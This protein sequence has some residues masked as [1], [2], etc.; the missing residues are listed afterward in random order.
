MSNGK[1]SKNIVD[2]SDKGMALYS[3]NNNTICRNNI[4]NNARKGIFLYDSLDNVIYLNNF[5]NN[6]VH[7]NDRSH[8][9]WDNGKQG[10]HWDDYSGV[11]ANSDGI[12]DSPYNIPGG[13]N[14]DKYPLM[15][16]YQGRI[17]L[18]DYYVDQ[19]LVQTIL[20][21]GIIFASIFCIPIGLWWRKKYFK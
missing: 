6:P 15:A 8:N 14:Q 11:D 17:I 3:C 19:D 7:A 10:N 18:D 12:G 20:I 4:T 5:I 21:V 9:K 16:P 13:D 1:I 2:N